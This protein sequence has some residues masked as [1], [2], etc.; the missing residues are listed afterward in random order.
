MNTIKERGI[1]FACFN[2]YLPYS[3]SKYYS[4]NYYSFN[5]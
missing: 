3:Y 2:S 4:S 5:I 1:N